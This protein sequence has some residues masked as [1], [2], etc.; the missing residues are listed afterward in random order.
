MAL[1][2]RDVEHIAHLA[3]LEVSDDELADY[4]DKLSNIIDL[5]AALGELDT[6]DVTPMAHP[7]DMAQRLR[8]DEVT[9]ADHRDE[10]Q[11]NAVS[12]GHGYYRV[13]KV[14]E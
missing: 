4:V 12:T 5:V 7:L 3:R 8:P 9:E 10:Y 1:T 11:R 6:T 13:P 2:T 14:I